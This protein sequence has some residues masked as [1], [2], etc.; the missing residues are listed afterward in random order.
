MCS[1]RREALHREPRTP[2][3][4]VAGPASTGTA[5]TKPVSTQEVFGRTL[6]SL[7]RDQALAPYLVMW[8]P[9]VATSTNLA[10]FINRVGVFARRPT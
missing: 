1:Q 2:A 3:A 10:G 4:P 5:S 8:A 6:V 7:S 9:D